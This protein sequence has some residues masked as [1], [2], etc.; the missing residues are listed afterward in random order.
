MRGQRNSWKLQQG[1]AGIAVPALIFLLEL[2]VFPEPPLFQS[3]WYLDVLNSWIGDCSDTCDAKKCLLFSQ[4]YSLASLLPLPAYFGRRLPGS[5]REGKVLL[6]LALFELNNVPRTPADSLS[7]P[8][9]KSFA[10]Q[11]LPS[12]WRVSLTFRFGQFRAEKKAVVH[13]KCRFLRQYR[14]DFDNSFF[15]GSAK[16]R[17]IW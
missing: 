9:V 6:I 8:G 5:A 13:L 12:P 2:P 3:F 14:M 10:F 1:A 11:A 4:V 17:S 7:H 16:D 15:P